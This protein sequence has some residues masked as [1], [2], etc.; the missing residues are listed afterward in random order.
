MQSLEIV[1]SLKC[2][3]G[4]GNLNEGNLISSSSF[5]REGQGKENRNRKRITFR[6][7]KW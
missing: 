4:N 7:R 6:N 5:C 2:K 1:Y 3:D